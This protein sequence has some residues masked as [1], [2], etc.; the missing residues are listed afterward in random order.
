MGQSAMKEDVAIF[1]RALILRAACKLFSE[2]GYTATTID[3]VTAEL[4]SSRRAIYDHFG[5]KAEMLVEICEQAV[6]F[7]LDLAEA[8]ARE[9]GDAAA[10]L[11]RLAH[12]FT[13]IVIANQDYIAVGSREMKF[14]PEPSYRRILRMQEKFD[15]LLGAILRDGID[16]GLFVIADP[17]MTALAMSGMIIW[18]HRW[19]RPNGRL[20]AEEIAASMAETAL[21]MARGK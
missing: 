11:R 18:V 10:K 6:R 5:G 21:R 14:L 15:G 8:V 19:Y 7:S 3:A 4:S 12:D 9:P 17:A 16:Q 13:L 1:K 20:S 2:R